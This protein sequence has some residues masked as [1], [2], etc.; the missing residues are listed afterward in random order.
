MTQLPEKQQAAWINMAV[1]KNTL[2]K[3]LET[4]ELGLQQILAAPA[5]LPAALTNYKKLHAEMV[6][7]RKG[8]TAAIQTGLIEPLMAYEKRA[9]PKTNARYQ[10]LEKKELQDRQVANAKAQAENAKNKEIADLKAHVQNEYHRICTKLRND[11]GR[12]LQKQYEFHLREDVSVDFGTIKNMLDAV[13]IDPMQKFPA[14][15]LTQAEML[16]IFNTIPK[17]N[18]KEIY[19]SFDIEAHF[20]NYNSDKKNAEAAIKNSQTQQQLQ[21]IENNRA[22][23]TETSLTTLIAASEVATVVPPKIKTEMKV[24]VEESEQWAK[25]VMAAFIVNLP[26]LQKYIRVKSWAK[27]TIGQMAEYLAKHVTETGE[28]IKGLKFEE[29]QK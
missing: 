5:D 21:E 1:A 25:A 15:H 28:V 26:Y 27:L 9:D 19:D 24:V 14:A 23:A 22:L 11:I 13:P 4:A 17:P 18:Y 3:E 6:E 7:K 16:E 29:V 10:E 2:V 20:A 8:F 12:D